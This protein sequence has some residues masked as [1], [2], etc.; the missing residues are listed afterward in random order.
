MN[1]F[2]QSNLNKLSKLLTK[3]NIEKFVKIIKSILKIYND[4]RKDNNDT[5][6]NKKKSELEK[7]EVVKHQNYE[8]AASLRDKET[9]VLDRLEE[10]KKIW[11]QIFENLK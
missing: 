1:Y 8:K 3:E 4:I 11:L 2:T 7:I 9:N 6:D 10:E 5:E